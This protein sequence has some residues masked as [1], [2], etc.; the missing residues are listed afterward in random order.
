MGAPHKQP[1]EGS[2]GQ[3][4]ALGGRRRSPTRQPTPST[5]SCLAHTA[6]LWPCPNQNRHANQFT[7]SLSQP[8]IATQQTSQIALAKRPL[9]TIHSLLRDRNRLACPTSFRNR[10]YPAERASGEGNRRWIE[11]LLPSNVGGRR[12]GRGVGDN[13][14][15][16]R[17]PPSWL[18]SKGDCCW[19]G[20]VTPS[21]KEQRRGR[22]EKGR[23]P[24]T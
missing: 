6:T 9:S 7:P 18:A 23:I 24:L 1:H 4:R 16:Q 13:Y 22:T 3:V 12:C 8:P 21:R 14:A 15:V 19:I 5:R 17:G 11:R 20:A 10:K 2:V